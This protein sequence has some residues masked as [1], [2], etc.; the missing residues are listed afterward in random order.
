LAASAVPARAN[1]I[2]TNKGEELA[3]DIIANPAQFFFDFQKDMESTNPLP[4]GN[5]IGFNWHIGQFLLIPIPDPTVLNLS[6]KLKLHSEGHWAPGVPQI[7]LIGGYWDAG[8][9]INATGAV[10]KNAT[11]AQADTKITD[12]KFN[13]YYAGAVMS[14]SLEPRVRM[15]WGYKYSQ[16]NADLTLNK[17][18]DFLGTKVTKFQSGFQDHFLFA[19]LEHPTDVNQWWNVQFFYGLTTNDFGAKVSWYHK[20]FELGLNIYPESVIVI[21]PVLNWHINFGT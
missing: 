16:M 18:I 8:P 13:G 12:A 6:G 20:N 2:F 5:W 19:G 21:H 3:A 14:S 17:G 7:D 10:D 11:A 15:F 9:L 4:P 1:D